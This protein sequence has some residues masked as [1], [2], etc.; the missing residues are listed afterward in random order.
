[1]TLR[2]FLAAAA[3]ALA[4]GTARAETPK[5]PPPAPQAGQPSSAGAGGDGGAKP[6]A[7]SM[8]IEEEVPRS[9]TAPP[10]P[11]GEEKAAIG[12]QIKQNT[13]DVQRCYA[14]ALERRPT[15]AGKLVVRFD[16]G[17]N[18]KVI[19]AAADGI[20]DRELV[21]CVVVA[22]RKW[23]FDKPQSGGKLRIAYPFKFE[24]QPS[25]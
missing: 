12:A 15:L 3:L 18:G 8:V 4:A 11:V 9:E 25:R 6:K 22:V 5:P 19:G 13:D 20:E 14:Q 7:A 24:P 21:S 10:A 2:P 1:M 23:E 16:I 17:S